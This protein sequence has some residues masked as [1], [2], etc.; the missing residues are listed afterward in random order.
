MKINVNNNKVEQY[1]Q[2]SNQDSFILLK[3]ILTT[4]FNNKQVKAVILNL[5]ELSVDF[6]KAYRN[7]GQVFEP[8]F[9]IETFTRQKELFKED[10]IARIVAAR[11]GFGIIHID[12]GI[13]CENEECGCDQFKTEQLKTNINTLRE[14]EGHFKFV[15]VRVVRDVGTFKWMVCAE[16]QFDEK[17]AFWHQRRDLK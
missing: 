13:E 12:L 4:P 11:K 3:E 10:I 7:T 14:W 5:P 17:D 2:C 8:K 15:D 16:V 6:L 9:Y 1:V